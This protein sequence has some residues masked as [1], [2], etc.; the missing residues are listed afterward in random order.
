MISQQLHFDGGSHAGAPLISRAPRGR[1]LLALVAVLLFLGSLSLLVLDISHT[2]HR[3]ASAP[4]ARRLAADNLKLVNDR[5][6]GWFT[7][8]REPAYDWEDDTQGW[9]LESEHNLA[10][11][12]GLVPANP[13]LQTPPAITE[14]KSSPAK[15]RAK[16]DS[17]LT[18]STARAH[19]N[20]KS[21]S[22]PVNFPEPATVFRANGQPDDQYP[23]VG[24]RFIAYDVFVPLEC[25]GFVGCL[26][27][28]KDKDGLWYQ[29]RSRA[30]LLPGEWTTI[31]ADL[32]G[33]S[34]DVT[35][36]GHQGQWDANQA[37]QIKTFGLTFYGDKPFKGSILLDNF[38]GWVRSDR[39][40]TT[41]NPDV[42]EAVE[43]YKEPPLGVLNFRTLPVG[44]PSADGKSAA[45]PSVKKF[46]TL[47]LRF[48]L[49]RQV[50]NPFDQMQADVTCEVIT[51][52]KKKLE[53][54]GFWYQDYDRTD[55][56]SGDDLEPVG[57]PEWRVRI[58]P[59]E[60][61]E[62]TYTVKLRI[63]KDELVLPPRKFI[64][65]ASQDRGFVRV[66]KTDP[67]FFEFENGEF[68][69]PVGHNL[70]SPVDL[71]C[72][73]QILHSEAPAGRGLPMYA[74]FF[75]KMR[76][77]GENTA[78]V[79]MASWWL[80]IEWTAKWRDYYGKGRYSLQHAWKLDTLLQMARDHGMH[81]H[82]V[83]D[84]HG[85]F[86][87]FCDWEWEL[88]PYNKREDLNGM[89]ISAKE[90]FESEE[91][92]RW[93]K[94]KLR[95]VAARWGADPTIMGFELVSEFDLVGGEGTTPKDWRRM[96]PRGTFHRTSVPQN[97]VRE[98][99]PALKQYDVYDHLV[100][101]HY[102]TD[103][104]YVDQIL[105]KE[106]IGEV[107]LFDY[108]VTDAY[109]QPVVG[110]YSLAARDMQDWV[111]S[112]V[113]PY[114]VKPFWITE[115]GGD[116]NAAAA[117]C[118]DAD[119]HAGLWGTWMT[120]GGGTPLMW[121]YDFIDQNNLYTYYGAFAKYIKGEDRRGLKGVMKGPH[122]GNKLDF[123]SYQWPT[124]AYMWVYDPK[125]MY[126]MPPEGAG[127]RF[128]TATEQIAGL[129]NGAYKVEYWNCYT[130]A[131]E[132]TET[133]NVTNGTVPLT[134]P[135]FTNN[136]AVKVKLAQ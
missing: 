80:G 17:K 94:N 111:S 125:A 119:V 130:G 10:L 55:R 59:R 8:K 106:K 116:F 82:L 73:Q 97:W 19:S 65:T 107:P 54:I 133:V 21:L 68:Y 24:V 37:T 9:M 122:G 52:S 120:E 32:R 123:Q 22:I 89:C 62:Y 92:K 29:A 79:W 16:S 83:L 99:I 25:P 101:N 72:W 124:G 41:A 126:S 49:N 105:A 45:L 88:N 129:T 96:S 48:E 87:S 13:D 75:P 63:K 85:K 131:V 34:P 6:S 128:D 26:F 30:S 102:A 78:E 77:N 117:P 28:M 135:P 66:S 134:F 57:R 61:G 47:T 114:A 38:R 115:Y 5:N 113:S 20:K 127:H 33:G 110:G 84:N 36:L 51:P 11:M 31:T 98:M 50:D 108:V 14:T 67:R 56:F 44:A 18:L 12:S 15:P 39:V 2:F 104:K 1:A 71:R 23:L 91:A 53:H 3:P 69:Y 86:S 95:Y 121:W 46:E 42:A 132:K 81:I 136:M 60:E 27:F 43:R 7:Y 35:P 109:R 112:K 70:H 118:L 76:A 100:T 58:T 74:D 103:F 93:H 4:L 64:A 40:G 90:F